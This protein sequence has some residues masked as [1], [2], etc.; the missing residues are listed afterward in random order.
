[1]SLRW[2]LEMFPDTKFVISF[3]NDG[4]CVPDYKVMETAQKIIN[5]KKDVSVSQGLLIDAIRVLV[6]E[7]QIDNNDFVIYFNNIILLV[8]KYGMV[9]HWPNGFCNVHENILNRLLGI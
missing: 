3:N 7:K 8:D 2:Q 1:M 6:K 9:D 4:L 5:E